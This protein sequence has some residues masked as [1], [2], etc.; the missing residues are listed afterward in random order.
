MAIDAATEDCKLVLAT[1][2]EYVLLYLKQP[3]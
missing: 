3:D 2:M 1:N